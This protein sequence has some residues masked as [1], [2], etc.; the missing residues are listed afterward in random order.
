M[1]KNDK[2]YDKNIDEILGELFSFRTARRREN[3]DD[4]KE[5]YNI[6]GSPCKNCRIIHIAGTNGKGS[7]ASFIENILLCAGYNVCK[8]TSPHIMKYNERIVSNKRKISDKKI[9]EYYFFVLE[10]LKKYNPEHNLN[11][12]EITFFIA[13]SYFNEQNPDFIILETGLGGRLDATNTINSDISVITNISFDHTAILGNTL[14]EIAYEKAGIIKNNGLCLYSH[15]CP[16]LVTEIGRRTS[17]SINVLKEYESV[18]IKLD[19]INFKTIVSIDKKEFIL[20]LFGKFQGHNFLLSYKISKIYNIDD[21]VIQEGLNSVYWP[22]RFEFFQKTPPVILDA[23]HNDDSIQKLTENLQ[24]LYAKNEVIII[25][26]FLE[27][28]DFSSV[29]SKLEKISDKIYITSLKN[30]VYGLT[31]LEIKEKM[32]SLGIPLKNIIFEDDIL[33]AYREALT[34]IKEEDSYRAIVICGSFYEISKFRTLIS[35]NNM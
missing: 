17:H 13:L 5:I 19:K 18:E 1:N 33:T 32:I 2:K 12:F 16:E 20:P 25:T 27:T 23:A 11:F 14:E 26:S 24:E 35:E 3:I 21:S 9:T 4:L 30:I 10:I 29:F 8:F 7:T 15:D 31:S 28:K 22:A 34:L 6:M